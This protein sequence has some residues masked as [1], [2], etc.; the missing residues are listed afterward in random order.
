MQ[1]CVW[2]PHG[3]CSSSSSLSD[4]SLSVA[5]HLPPPT[6]PPTQPG[7]DTAAV[8]SRASTDANTAATSQHSYV[9]W[10]AARLRYASRRTRSRN[11]VSGN[12]G[13]GQQPLN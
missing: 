6:R 7:A 10:R 9:R 8:L 13:M 2:A 12:E 5:S 4:N 3:I 11:F 1:V